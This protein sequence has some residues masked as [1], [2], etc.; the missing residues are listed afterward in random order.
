MALPGA[1]PASSPTTLGTPQLEPQA[2]DRSAR[3]QSLEEGRSVLLAGARCLALLADQ[4][5]DPFVRAAE[6]ILD[7]RGMLITSGIGKAGH[8]ATKVSATF[9]STGT[10]SIFLHP[11]EAVHGDLGRVSRLDVVLLFSNSGVSP[12]LIRLIQPLRG[13]GAT[14]IA[15]TASADSALARE[16]DLV[17]AYGPQSEAGHLGLAPTTSTTAMLGLGD[18]LALAVFRRRNF[19]PRDF[20]RFHPAGALG[21]SLTRVRDV[22]RC[23]A[24][25][26]LVRCDQAVFEALHV[27]STTP[28]RPGAT[29]VVDEQGR[30]VGFYTDG[31]FRRQMELAAQRGEFAFLKD[32]LTEHMTRSPRTIAPDRLVGDAMRMLREW[33]IDQ[34]PV[35]DEDHRPVGLLDV[36]DLLNVRVLS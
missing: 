28:G 13:I 27:I 26:P 16:S 10:P 14:L 32:P 30:L 6:A 3:A 19:T 34:L 25:N 29:S 33:K 35:V 9:A 2:D 20:A 24:S 12:E 4:L 15:V 7:G 1:G 5:G 22:M 11:T 17:L 18:A 21:L 36:Q 31:D 23:E 8:V